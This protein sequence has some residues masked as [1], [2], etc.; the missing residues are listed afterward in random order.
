MP[1]QFDAAVI[2]SGPN[3]LAAA[4]TLARAGL[5]V[6]IYEAKQSVGGGMRSGALT[7]P[8]FVHDF[9]S[10]IHPLALSSPFFR[11]F[12][13]E[14][15]NLQWI[16]PPSAL[17]HPFEDGSALLLDPLN[18]PEE[19]KMVLKPFVKKWELLTEE[20][21]SP[22]HFPRHP[23]TLLRFGWSALHSAR[24]FWQRF[25][26]RQTRALFA[27]LAG[28]SMMPLN[29]P[30]T[31]AFGLV[32]GTLGL[33]VGW[34]LAK[35]GSQ[36]IADAL[37]SYFLSLGG[38]IELSTE[39]TNID[40]LPST[41]LT[42]CDLSPKQLLAIA[43]HRLPKRYMSR[44]K[45]F[46]YGPGVFKIDWALSQPIPWQSK[47]CLNAATVHLGNSAEEILQAEKAIFAGQH[48]QQPFIILAQQSLFD[49]SRAPKGQQTAWAYCHVPHNS[50][51]NMTSQIESQIERFAPGFKECILARHTRTAHEMEAYNPN[52]VGGDI[53]SG[54]LDVRQFFSRPSGLLNPYATPLKGVFL[55]SSSTPPG[56][57]VHGMCGYHA[58][59]VALKSLA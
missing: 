18:A 10:A 46:R 22:F 19:F 4:I 38:H 28:H 26:Q 40:A 24:S 8:G 58:A 15:W 12:P 56:G 30:L 37:L 35:G 53:N 16:F 29:D 33:K 5:S 45:K 48:P 39:I 43:G 9:C 13:C 50:Q 23:L 17:A 34:P 36:K 55:C 21:L 20:I 7:L 6:V 49:T 31:A 47:E 52:Y 54:L 57:G 27:G 11:T 32:L 42:L 41:K 3:G 51:V 14:E 1:N 25:Q 44:L 2:G 59:R